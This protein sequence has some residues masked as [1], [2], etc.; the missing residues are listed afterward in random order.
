MKILFCLEYYPP[1]QGS[2]RTIFE[3]SKKIKRKK[4][5]IFYIIVPP[6]RTLWEIYKFGVKSNRSKDFLKL[7]YYNTQKGNN[8]FRIK[9]PPWLLRFWERHLKTAYLLTSILNIM[10]A[11]S[12][13]QKIKP[14][15]ILIN[16]PSPSSGLIAL[17]ICKLLRKPFVMGFPDMISTYAMDLIRLSTGNYLGTLILLLETFLIKKS[18]RIFTINEYLKNYLISLKYNEKSIEIIPNGVDI[19]L[20]DHKKNGTEIL[21]HYALKNNYIILYVGHIEQWAGIPQILAAATLLESS[22]PEIK[23]LFVGDGLLRQEI[24][25]HKSSKNLILTGLQPYEKIPE[26]IASSDLTIAAFPNSITTHA[27]SPLKVFEYMAMAKPV[28]TTYIQG[29]KDVIINNQNGFILSSDNPEQIR[30]AILKIKNDPD[31]SKK[32]SENALKTIQEKYTWQQAAKKLIR[33]CI[34][35]LKEYFH[36]NRS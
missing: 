24:E 29:L 11:L 26:F 4:I 27:A 34:E 5:D 20:F 22:N 19:D 2:D 6:L 13:T 17:L 23:F 30:N 3:L 14:D 16:H 15:I 10:R 18:P 12:F 21:T 25:R 7:C 32:L 31:F 33:F 9:L 35:Y 28:I 1:Y 8:L 36:K